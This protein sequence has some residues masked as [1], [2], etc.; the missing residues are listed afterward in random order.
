VFLSL[1][2]CDDY[3]MLQTKSF[4][5]FSSLTTFSDPVDPYANRLPTFRTYLIMCSFMR[6]PSLGVI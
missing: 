6:Y 4:L 2:A 3:L 5:D 1:C